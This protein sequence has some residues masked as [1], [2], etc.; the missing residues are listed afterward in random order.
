M[1]EPRATV[2]S[3]GVPPPLWPETLPD[4]Q[5]DSMAIIGPPRVEYSQMRKGPTRTRVIARTAPME[6]MFE[7]WMTPQQMKEFESWHRTVVRYSDGEFYARW[8]GGSRVVAFAEPYQYTALGK[9]YVLQGHVI[10][11]RIDLSACDAFI[12]AVFGNIYRDDG[13]AADIYRADLAAVDI[14]KDDYPLKLI[15]GNEC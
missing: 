7:I 2:R 1:G 3:T 9:G 5:A 13:Q 4:P 6:F 10:R 15:A 11:T 8:I 14:Y 12:N